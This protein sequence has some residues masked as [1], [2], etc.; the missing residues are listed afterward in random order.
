LY[1]PIFS[2]S[3][4]FTF[5]YLNVEDNIYTISFQTK[6]SA[7]PK[8]NYCLST[9]TLSFDIHSNKI[10]EINFSFL[11]YAYSELRRWRERK[12]PFKTE[13]SVKIGYDAEGY[14]YISQCSCSSTWNY[15]VGGEN[16]VLGEIRP[17]RPFAAKNRLVEKEFWSC[18]SYKAIPESFQTEETTVQASWARG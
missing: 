17:S 5:K 4:H 9:G 16:I 14:A 8:K 2:N 11:D 7:Y 18:D 1:G 12:F 13:A 10:I 15:V 6:A 3:K